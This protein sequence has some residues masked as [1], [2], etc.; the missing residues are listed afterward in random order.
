MA[1]ARIL[2]ARRTGHRLA[3]LWC[4]QGVWL[5]RLRDGEVDRLNIALGRAS[6][7]GWAWADEQPPIAAAEIYLPQ[8]DR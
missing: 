3:W 8:L 6:A 4:D 1:L 5:S 7:E 2:R